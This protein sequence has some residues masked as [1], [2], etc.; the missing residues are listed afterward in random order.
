MIE[1]RWLIFGAA[2]PGL[3]AAAAFAATAWRR[4]AL[5]T[6]A[7]ALALALAWPVGHYVTVGLPHAPWNVGENWLLPLALLTALVAAIP[8][9]TWWGGTTAR[10]LLL[11]GICYAMMQPAIVWVWSVPQTVAWVGGSALMASGITEAVVL[12]GRGRAGRE[13][14]VGL[15]L[16][17]FVT[18][19]VCAMSSSLTIGQ[20]GLLLGAITAGAGLAA[21]WLPCDKAPRGA[22]AVVMPMLLAVIL[23]GT[24]SAD[25]HLRVAVLLLAAPVMMWAGELPFIKRRPRLV[26]AAVRLVALLVPLAVALALVVPDFIDAINSPYSGY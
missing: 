7:W 11:A 26:V 8:W 6:V 2:T 12:L 14:P 16:T 17:A 20:F 13:L 19:V 23:Y 21:F 9:P 3:I 18:G 4:P 5:S 10:A 22:P 24:H 25:V 15:A 1:P